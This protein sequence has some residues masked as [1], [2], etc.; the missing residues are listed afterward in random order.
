MSR[1]ILNGVGEV[2]SL[3]LPRYA[4]DDGEIVVAEAV[5]QV[6]FSIARVFTLTAPQGARRGEH[7]HR[8]CSQ[9]LLC[10]HGSVELVCDDGTDRK[11]FLLDRNNCAVYVPPTIW[12]T[13]I[14]LKHRSV[15]IVLCDRPFEEADYLRTYP[16]FIAFRKAP[17]L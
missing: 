4:R 8:R 3:T 13:V 6:P 9:L 12:N 5:A 15:V 10:V 16:E 7:A 1:G 2:R 11:V 17:T 14:F